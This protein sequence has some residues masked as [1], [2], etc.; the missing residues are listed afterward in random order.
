M[1]DVEKPNF[2]KKDW[3]WGFEGG[4]DKVGDNKDA[5][6]QKPQQAPVPAKGGAFG[7]LVKLALLLVVASGGYLTYAH[8]VKVGEQRN[9]ADTTKPAGFVP[10]WEW[11]AE[12]RSG[13][14]DTAKATGEQVKE[15]GKVATE[16][17]S[18]KADELKKR[19]EERQKKRAA[20][21]TPAN[22][23]TPPPADPAKPDA[24]KPAEP[25][26]VPS[27]AATLPA[28]YAKIHALVVDAENSFLKDNAKCKKSC[29][30]AIAQLKP[31]AEKPPVHAQVQ[32]DLKLV[33][34]LLQAVNEQ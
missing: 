34:D 11:T 19:I 3:K 24:P 29:E 21:P 1:A 8:G 17:W 25:A 6:G 28:D 31:L 10:P 16:A 30:D 32:D 9:K 5:A 20:E 26:A 18:K 2:G 23:T 4:G 14:S 12:E 7:K 33:T 22:A 27:P 13:I 15:A